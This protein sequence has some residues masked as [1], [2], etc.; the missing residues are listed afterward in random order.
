MRV[1]MYFSFNI[2]IYTFIKCLLD[3][4]IYIFFFTYR[5]TCV[6][7][8]VSFLFSL[9]LRYSH[10]HCDQVLRQVVTEKL[11]KNIITIITIKYALR[12]PKYVKDI[13][14]T[15]NTEIDFVNRYIIMIWKYI[16]FNNIR[17]NL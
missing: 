12:C 3:K 8:R 9:Q 7:I 10:S 17:Y 15:K 5:Y 2:C 14:L 11:A 1:F 4:N 6:H 13:T 16:T